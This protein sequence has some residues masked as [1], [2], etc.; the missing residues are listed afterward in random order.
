MI[1]ATTDFI[2]GK[3]ITETIGLVEGSTIRARHV[4]SDIGAGLKSLIGG[5]IRGYVKAMN[6]ARE[7]ALRRMEES[8]KARGADAVVSVRFSTSHVMGGAAEILAYGT[9]VKLHS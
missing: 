5:E 4:G 3:E 2:S 8:A 7:E 9:A 1:I 6:A